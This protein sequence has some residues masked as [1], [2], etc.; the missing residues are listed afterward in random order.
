MASLLYALL[1]AEM[2]N[3][4]LKSQASSHVVAVLNSKRFQN[5]LLRADCLQFMLKNKL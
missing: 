2:V 3:K 1:N 5:S 4:Q